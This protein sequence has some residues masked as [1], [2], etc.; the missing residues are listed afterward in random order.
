M[1]PIKIQL[2]EEFF[3]E[4]VRSGYTVSEEMKKVWAV[5]L[6]MLVEFDRICREIGVKYFLDAG[7]LLGA[8]RHKGFIPWDDDID[9]AVLREDYEKLIQN[10]GLFREPYFFQCAY[11]DKG[12]FRAHAQLRNSKTTGILPSE[13]KKV[14]FNQGIFLDIFPYDG[15]CEDKMLRRKQSKKIAVYKKRI[16][17]MTKVYSPNKIKGAI[18]K[19]RAELLK[20]PYGS[21]LKQYSRFEEEC[22]RYNNSGMIDCIGL[23]RNE[24]EYFYA[25]REWYSETLLKEFEGFLFPVPSEYDKALKEAYG[26]NYMIPRKA[27]SFHG[28]VILDTQKSYIEYLTNQ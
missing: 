2:P 28:E 12:Y 13:G 19:L 8:I 20:I 24:E 25:P 16:R 27:S 17:M 9:V 10:A 22:K 4:E 11:T 1:L 5:E 3:R 7:T 26:E 15:I 6:D 21:P 14:P 18:K 23:R